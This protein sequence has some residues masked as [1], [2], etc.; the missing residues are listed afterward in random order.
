MIFC[1]VVQ[2]NAVLMKMVGM[3]S[4]IHAIRAA[5]VSHLKSPSIY[6]K[7]AFALTL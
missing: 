6:V 1:S 3:S 4:I 5:G 2:T 7:V